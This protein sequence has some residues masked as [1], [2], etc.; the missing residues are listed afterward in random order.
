M[1]DGST[2][3]GERMISHDAFMGMTDEHWSMQDQLIFLAE[4][5]DWCDLFFRVIKKEWEAIGDTMEI[6]CLQEFARSKGLKLILFEDP[7]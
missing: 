1:V 4:N 5:Q 2:E 3:R 7:E 6:S